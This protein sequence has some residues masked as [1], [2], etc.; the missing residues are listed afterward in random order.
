VP[1]ID[2]ERDLL[3]RVQNSD[4][5]AFELLFRRY[6]PVLFRSVMYQLRNAEAAHDIVQETFTRVWERRSSLKPGLSFIAYL[7]R[8]STNLVRDRQRH[9]GTRLKS[10]E[11]VPLPIP[12]PDADPVDSTQYSFLSDAVR[13]A[14]KDDLPERCRMVF[15]LSRLE[16]M[17]NREIAEQLRISEKTVE[18]QITKAL[19]ILQRK[20]R[21]F[22]NS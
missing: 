1:Q 14:L 20:L 2:D 9:E 15:E 18:N 21:A 12:P 3:E 17:T 11:Q 8:I 4:L 22:R 10:R 7:F 13:R 19:R 6:Q 5:E 16:G